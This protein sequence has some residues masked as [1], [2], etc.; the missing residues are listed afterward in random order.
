MKDHDL[1]TVIIYDLTGD[2][3]AKEI[4]EQMIKS[5]KIK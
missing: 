4:S 5:I 2:N 1:W 3:I